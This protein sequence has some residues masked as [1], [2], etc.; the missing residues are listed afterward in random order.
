MT[1]TKLAANKILN[2]ILGVDTLTR[3][4]KFHVGLSTTTID[5]N[6]DGVSEPTA[7]KNYYRTT[8]ETSHWNP[9]ENSTITNGSQISFLKATGNWGVIK[10]IFISECSATGASGSCI[11]FHQPV[12]PNIPVLSGTTVIIPPESLV[13]K[14]DSDAYETG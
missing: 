4:T 5:R 13:I 7:G 11:W 3:P 14:R 1:S 10:E 6:G 12:I 2:N 8:I 9:A